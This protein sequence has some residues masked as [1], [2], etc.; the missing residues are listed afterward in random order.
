ME[1]WA[2]AS[3]AAFAP[4][5]DLGGFTRHGGRLAEARAAFP[6]APEPW[7]DLSTG[8]NPRPWPLR[9]VQRASLDRLP[10]P[11]EIAAL[12]R[13]AAQAFGADPAGV[14]AVPG[15]DAGLRLLPYLTGARDVAIVEPTY[16]GHRAAWEVAGAAVR[17]IDR[18]ELARCEAAA[19]VVV[20]PNNPDGGVI[21]PQQLR[22]LARSR[23]LIVDESFVETQPEQSVAAHVSD[24]MVLL[25]SFGKFYG[26][27]G[28]RLGF[29]IAVPDVAVRLRAM[30]GDW[31][32]SSD[33]VAIGSA[34]YADQAWRDITLARLLRDSRR[35]DRVLKNAGFATRGGTALFRLAETTDAH[36]WFRKLSAQGILVR[37]F[38]AQPTWLRFGI[39]GVQD[40]AR[41][42]AALL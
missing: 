3:T 25:R 31:P 28:L 29:V 1:R 23:W 32:V 15:A 14:V 40:C 20:N 26:L 9:R 36:A 41:L 39:P 2:A 30:I 16:S 21:S 22:T 34:A 10:D 18:N 37:A 42:E 8:I 24:R 35:L 38:D 5:S 6:H 27:A 19:L 7:I 12:E 33:A 13:I 11:A 4:T 17:G